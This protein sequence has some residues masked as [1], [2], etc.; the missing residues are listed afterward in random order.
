MD[1]RPAT[2]G[3]FTAPLGVSPAVV[4]GAPLPPGAQPV[5]YQP[6]HE[7]PAPD[8][9]ASIAELQKI[10][11]EMAQKAAQQEGS[12]HRAVHAKGQALLRAQLQV[13]NDLPPH[14]AQG[15]FATP[16]RYEAIVRFSSPPAE[17]LPDGVS[18]PRAM[19]LKVLGVHGERVPESPDA[20]TQ[21]FLMVNAPAFVRPDPKGFIADA[22]LLALTTGHSPRGKELLST[23]LRGAEAV[24][25]AVG[26][27]ATKLKGIGGQP[28]THPLGETY[29]TQ[30]PFLYGEHIA[31]F[32][33]APA[34]PALTALQGTDIPAPA[35]RRN[36][37]SGRSRAACSNA[38]R[39][40]SASSP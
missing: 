3:T 35:M 34:S 26:V 36:K 32:S 23:V 31:K 1:P 9:A 38:P 37:A 33:L 15:L 6:A 13:L 12:A 10:F 5:R 16:A 11:I 2:P 30:V 17:Q 14:L 7:H 4:H 27:E 29:F 8:E 18:T 20:H 22:R 21:D 19:A 25:Q 40:D 39:P 24:L 28:P